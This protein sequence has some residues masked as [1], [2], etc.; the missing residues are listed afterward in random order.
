[1]FVYV[2]MA[3]TFVHVIKKREKISEARNIKHTIEC[4]NIITGI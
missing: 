1:M 3:N 2:C 4:T